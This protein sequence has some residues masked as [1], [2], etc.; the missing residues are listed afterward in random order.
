MPDAMNAKVDVEVQTGSA[1]FDADCT[2]APVS[3]RSIRQA[4]FPATEDTDDR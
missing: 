2:D 3:A 1:A 4:V